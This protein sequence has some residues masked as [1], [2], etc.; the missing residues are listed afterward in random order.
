MTQQIFV[1]VTFWNVKRLTLVRSREFCILN[2]IFETNYSVNLI[3]II[4][5]FKEMFTD[6]SVDQNKQV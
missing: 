2:I 6:G 1:T 4:V 5:F 3:N